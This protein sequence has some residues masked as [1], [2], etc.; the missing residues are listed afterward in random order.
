M[1]YEFKLIEEA[2]VIPDPKHIWID[3]EVVRVYTDE[4]IPKPPTTE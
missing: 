4:D 3:G 1:I 2:E